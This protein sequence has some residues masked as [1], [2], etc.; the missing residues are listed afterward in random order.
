MIFYVDMR[1]LA[2][3]IVV[4]VFHYEIKLLSVQLLN[5]SAK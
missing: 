4:F 2:F 1:I 3:Q 5:V